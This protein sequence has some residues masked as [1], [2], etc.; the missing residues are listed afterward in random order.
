MKRSW[1]LVIPVGALLLL[2]AS[3]SRGISD[4]S[5]VQS[6]E[7]TGMRYI[8]HQVLL[9]SGDKTSRVLPVQKRPDG[10]YL[11]RFEKPFTP[12]PDSLV[13]VFTRNMANHKEYQVELV[14]RTKNEMLYSFVIDSDGS[15]SILPCLK[16][17]LPT[18][19]YD[20]VIKMPAS[21]NT[22]IYIGAATVLLAA[23]GMLFYQNRKKQRVTPDVI[24]D[25]SFLTIGRFRFYADQH[26]L[27]T[28]EHS[29]VLTPKEGQVLAI[30][31]RSPNTVI[32]RS[33]LQKEVWDDEG[34]LITR[35]L[36]MFISKLRKKL[37]ADPGVSIVNVHGR[38]YRLEIA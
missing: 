27:E 38:G 23:G 31:A 35:S 22:A 17:P 8:G 3:G 6:K 9:S 30:L 19:Y 2:I 11:L 15:R 13:S 21:S 14:E 37:K 18:G 29:I 24:H 20:L 4:A 25:G 28:D 36:D 32:E 1:L 33:R 5:Y 16:R 12:V 7:K 26:K 10:A 34:V